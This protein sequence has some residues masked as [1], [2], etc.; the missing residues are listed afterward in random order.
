MSLTS[1]IFKIKARGSQVRGEAKMKTASL[2]E[3]LYGFDSG[4]SKKAVQENRRK[5]E[6]LKKDKGFVFEVS[7]FLH[8]SSCIYYLLNLILYVWYQAISRDSDG[9][10]TR[11]GIYKHPIIQKAVNAMWFKNKRD[12]GILYP[13]LFK[14]I[15]IHCIALI[16]TAVSVSTD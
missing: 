3:A 6:E 11:K 7:V 15:S 12:E 4:R 2:V 13:D 5:A 8:Y 14:P 9:K 16:L 10:L 1:N